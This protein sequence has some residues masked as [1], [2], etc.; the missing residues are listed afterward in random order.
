MFKR[1]E[2]EEG[3]SKAIL[4]EVSHWF[5]DGEPFN[6]AVLGQVIDGLTKVE[7]DR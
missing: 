6:T 4:E 5:Y 1:L 7:N 3:V 2:A